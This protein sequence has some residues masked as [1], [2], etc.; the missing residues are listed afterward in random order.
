MVFNFFISFFIIF[1]AFASFPDKPRSEEFVHDYASLLTLSDENNL[2]NKL[3]AEFRRSNTPIVFVTIN[4]MSEYSN[5]STI[6]EFAREWFNHWGIGTLQ[7]NKGIL[8]LISK[9][10]RK[11]RIELGVDWAYQWNSSSQK[12]VDQKILPHFKRGNFKKGILEGADAIIKMAQTGPRKSPPLPSKWESIKDYKENSIN[13]HLTGMAPELL[14][15]FFWAGITCIIA[16]FIFPIHKKNLLIAGIGLLA[17]VLIF[18]VILVILAIYSKGR[19]IGSTG[20]RGGF[21]GGSSG[22]GGA[23]GGW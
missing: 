17:F 12:I 21:G 18:Y 3:G 22:G 15:L 8:V 4:S 23:S 13:D 16:A 1:N 6:E 20:G 14:N 2:K 7:D 11:M 5:S 19:R 9:N 10:D